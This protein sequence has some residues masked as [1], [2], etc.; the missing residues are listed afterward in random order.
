WLDTSS[1]EVPNNF[2]SNIK[3]VNTNTIDAIKELA[4]AKLWIGAQVK[5]YLLRDGLIK[6]DG[7]IYI[8]TWHGSLGIKKIGFD[9]NPHEET[10]WT[11]LDKKEALMLDYTISNSDF[12]NNVYRS[13]FFGQGKTVLLGHARNDIFFKDN[14][15]IKNK[16]K[17]YYRLNSNKKI[18]MYAPT[19]RDDY[20][21]SAYNMDYL[22][23]LKTFEQY[24]NSE[25][26]LFL[27][28]HPKF[29]KYKDKFIPTSEKIID[30]TNYDDVQELLVSSDFLITDYSSIIFDFMLT[31][32]PAFIYASDIEKYN[33]NRGFYYPLEMTPFPIAKSNKEM[34]EN[35]HNFDEEKYI[36]EVDLFL[37]NKGC[38]DDG[39]ASERIVDFIESIL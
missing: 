27:R 26:V 3:V 12:E 38:I 34:I 16:V 29:T 14:C 35:I 17:N 19:F 2:P 37:T 39:H 25:C 8:Q 5:S 32:K 18:I 31:R 7:Q 6:K 20:D 36:K 28:I 30:V 1:K 15:D 4:T 23:I 9:I 24:F 11:L 10:P 13:A 22:K 21:F 33:T